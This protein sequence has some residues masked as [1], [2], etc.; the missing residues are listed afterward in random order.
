MQW[1]IAHADC[2]E[3]HRLLYYAMLDY[4]YRL[5]DYVTRQIMVY[6]S[7]KVFHK[8]KEAHDAYGDRGILVSIDGKWKMEA[9]GW[10]IQPMWITTWCTPCPRNGGL[11]LHLLLTCRFTCVDSMMIGCTRGARNSISQLVT[12]PRQQSHLHIVFQR[13]TTN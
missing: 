1:A 13:Q 6:S 8:L 12:L 11:R 10:V 9:N 7:P 2:L 5:L 4:M 3:T